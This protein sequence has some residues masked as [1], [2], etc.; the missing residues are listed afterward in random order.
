MSNKL[1]II[2]CK[3]GEDGTRVFSIRMRESLVAEL[4]QM[5]QDSRHSR[6]ELINLM[7]EY[8]MQNTEIKDKI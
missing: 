6:N 4:D 8:A 5:V 1:T 3:R 7:I 2:K